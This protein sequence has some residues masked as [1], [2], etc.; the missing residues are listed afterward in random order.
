MITEIELRSLVWKKIRGS[1]IKSIINGDVYLQGNRPFNSEK[2]D[3]VIAG[4]TAS[5]FSVI[6]ATILVQIFAKNIQSNG[7]YQP[8]Y[9]TLNNATKYIISLF[10]DIYFP[11]TKTNIDYESSNSYQVEGV[12][13]WVSVIRL[14]TRTINF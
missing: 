2:T 13:E 11:D 14:K 6:P 10:D 8:D 9:K 7:N 1:D 12:Q 5:N 4:L 3:I